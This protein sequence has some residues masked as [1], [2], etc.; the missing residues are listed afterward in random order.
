MSEDRESCVP[1]KIYI[2]YD[3]RKSQYKLE[4]SARRMVSLDPL[5]RLEAF[6]ICPI[7][8]WTGNAEQLFLIAEDRNPLRIAN[9]EGG[10]LI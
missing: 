1:L 7:R 3:D 6:E 4:T 9:V 10:N 2:N 8:G 5:K